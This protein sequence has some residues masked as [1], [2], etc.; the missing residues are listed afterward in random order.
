MAAESSDLLTVTSSDKTT[1]EHGKGD[2]EGMDD[3]VKAL[4]DFSAENDDGETDESLQAM[5]ESN[6]V[7][8]SYSQTVRQCCT[9]QPNQLSCF[10]RAHHQCHQIMT[11]NNLTIAMCTKKQMK[12]KI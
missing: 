4:T 1:P 11:I 9:W 8:I 12:R 10:Y 5:L 7:T 2:N 6:T 3:I